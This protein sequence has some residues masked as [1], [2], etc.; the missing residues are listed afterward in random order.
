MH[1]SEKVF[2][3][4]ANETKLQECLERDLRLSGL[5]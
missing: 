3:L 5:Q 1:A 4:N 2:K